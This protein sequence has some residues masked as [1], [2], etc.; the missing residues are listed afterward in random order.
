[1]SDDDLS[2]LGDAQHEKKKR[3]KAEKARGAWISFAGR[4]V[5]QIVG[6]VASV[7]LGVMVLQ[8]YQNTPPPASGAATDANATAGAAPGRPTPIQRRPGDVAI[9][10]LPLDNLSRDPDQEYFVDGMTEAVIAGL[11]RLDGL[12]VISR[13]STTRY[14]TEHPAIP[15]IA[16]ALGADL[17]VEGSVLQAG[18][19][20]RITA[21][22]I[23]GGT[24]EHLWT[25]SYTRTLKDVIALQDTVSTAIATA[26]KGT[27]TRRPGSRPFTEHA[28]EPSVYDLYLRGRHAWS[29]RTPEGLQAA[30]DF[31]EKAIAL[32]PAFAL[33]HVGMADTYAL[34]GSPAAGLL[35]QQASMG[36]AKTA[37]IRAL[38]LDFGLAEAHTALGGVLFFGD[39]DYRGAEGA[40]TKALELNPNY[41][42]AHEWLA[43]L[44]AEQ[45][46]DKEA[47]DHIQQAVR[48]DPLE[49]SM[50]QAHGVVHYYARRHAAAVA[51]LRRA[52]ELS[53]RLPLARAMLV[54]AQVLDGD[55]ATALGSC[56]TPSAATDADL[57]VACAV[58]AYRA[59]RTAD[60]RARRT[61]LESR[62][63]APGVAL[64]QL[65]SALGEYDAAFVRL[66]RL[67]ARG[68]L[69]PA[70][71]FDPLFDGLRRDRRWPSVAALL[72]PRPG[73]PS[74]PGPPPGMPP[75]GTAAAPG[76][77]RSPR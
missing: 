63:P 35:D 20:V 21:Q 48:L 52:L 45:G 38:D 10:V 5:A 50:H 15:E 14:K 40:F 41:P 74:G 44:L 71:A 16:R 2:S 32:D 73:P 3:K 34:Q 70:L 36:K 59:G 23:D 49:G 27:V 53:P 19:Q 47:L 33:A 72:A 28:V 58:A 31:F 62:R 54:K 51:P 64:A 55:P 60:A 29:T 42:V 76:P 56:E 8:R 68:N 11:A 9:A 77:P 57:L 7:V 25:E 61:A 13:T 18:D 12:R 4:I 75:P 43:V 65:D 1:M 17:I 66:D 37:A 24:D 69:P 26:I 39:R 46:R 6:A 67:G 22:L 30:L